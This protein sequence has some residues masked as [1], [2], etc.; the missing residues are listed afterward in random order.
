MRIYLPLY[1]T[2]TQKK[3]QI[4]KG[5]RCFLLKFWHHKQLKYLEELIV[6]RKVEYEHDFEI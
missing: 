2:P 3:K 4:T 6:T 1:L 5:L